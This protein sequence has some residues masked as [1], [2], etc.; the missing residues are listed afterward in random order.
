MLNQ[1]RCKLLPGEM[2]RVAVVVA[3][4]VPSL[5]GAVLVNDSA[6]QLAVKGFLQPTT[7]RGGALLG[8]R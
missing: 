5:G 2:L 7:H 1:Q 3:H 6:E 4:Q 8:R